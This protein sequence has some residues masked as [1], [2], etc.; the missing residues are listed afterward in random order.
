MLPV[1]AN[2]SGFA[3]KMTPGKHASLVRGVLMMSCNPYNTTF[4][5]RP[6]DASGRGGTPGSPISLLHTV[7]NATALS[8]TYE[9]FAVD[10]VTIESGDFCAVYIECNGCQIA[11]D[12]ESSWSGRTMTIILGTSS[13]I[14]V[15]MVT[16]WSVLYW[17][18]YS[19]LV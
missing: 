9:D 10:S 5:C 4:Q 2:N 8:W 19:V 12:T 18:P 3:L 16:T 11:T 15:R 14:M 13:P 7:N 17:I 1:G 6:W